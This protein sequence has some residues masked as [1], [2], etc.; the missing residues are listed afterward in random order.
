MADAPSKVYCLG[1]MH[2]PNYYASAADSP[3]TATADGSASQ[4]SERFVYI[5]NDEDSKMEEREGRESAQIRRPVSQRLNLVWISM[6]S[7]E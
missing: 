2:W 1:K 6:M 5:F 7:K 3:A 4:V